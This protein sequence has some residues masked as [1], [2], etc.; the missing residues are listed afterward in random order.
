MV[1]QIFF[2]DKEPALGIMPSETVIG[3]LCL[4]DGYLKYFHICFVSH[5]RDIRIRQ[6][7]CS[8]CVA[9]TSLGVERPGDKSIYKIILLQ[10]DRIDFIAAIRL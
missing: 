4:D 10:C 5:T 9:G 6:A 2:Q 7:G 1:F 8:A 3:H